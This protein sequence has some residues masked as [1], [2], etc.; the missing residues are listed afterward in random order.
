MALTPV[1][2]FTPAGY[3][4]LTVTQTSTN[5]AL[6][7]SGNTTALI[8]NNGGSGVVILLGNGSVVVTPATGLYLGPGQSI[9]LG[10]GA[11]TNLAAIFPGGVFESSLN[12]AVGA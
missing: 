1:S 5:V 4:Q 7:G 3:V 2:A 10:I 6:P 8:T 9:Y 12:I 11:N